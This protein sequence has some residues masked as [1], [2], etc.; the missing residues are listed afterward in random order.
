MSI[1]GFLQF[2]EIQTK[3]ASIIPFIL[4]TLYSMYRFESFKP[5]NFLIMLI[6]LLAFDM[7]TTAINNY[8]DY[9]KSRLNEGYNYKQKNALVRDGISEKAALTVIFILLSIATAFGIILTL[10]TDFIVLFIGIIS[11][12]VGIFYTFGPIPISRMPLG[13][14]FS[15]IFMGFIIMFLAVYI[16]IYDQLIIALTLDN[17]VLNISINIK[18]IF[19]IFL[20]SIPAICGIANIMLANNICDIEED[21]I[22]KRYTLPYYL[23][24]ENALKLFETIYY[25]GYL[26]IILI[27]ALGIVPKISLLVLLTVIPVY[28]NI[29]R[30]KKM[31]L[32]SETFVLSVKNFALM[33]TAEILLIGLSVVT[34][35][36]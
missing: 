8:L 4:G 3:L 24:R 36:R 10:Q 32:K 19:F 35:L 9:K 14:L 13:E 31:P 27:V 18:E 1:G 2:V 11:F 33:K 30:F 16:H 21:I 22:N 17:S 12:L 25:I 6:S 5:E 26:D 23:G 29:R 20:L 7:A 28:G 34:G 15:G